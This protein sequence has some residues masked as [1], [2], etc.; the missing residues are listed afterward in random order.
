MRLVGSWRLYRRLSAVRRR[1][2]DYFRLRRAYHCAIGNIRRLG[3]LGGHRASGNGRRA[4]F[5][6][7]KALLDSPAKNGRLA[8]KRQQQ[9][10]FIGRC[11]LVVLHIDELRRQ[12][13]RARVLRIAGLPVFDACFEHR[14]IAAVIKPHA[15]QVQPAL[16][17]VLVGVNHQ[18]VGLIF[19]HRGERFPGRV[20]VLLLL[21]GQAQ[22][23]LLGDQGPQQVQRRLPLAGVNLRLP[24]ARQLVLLKACRIEFAQQR[25]RALEVVLRQLHFYRQQRPFATLRSVKTGR[26]LVEQLNGLR[27]LTFFQQC[28]NGE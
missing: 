26:Q 7:F 2:I 13:F 22:Q 23:R 11:G 19:G 12:H 9:R 17:N 4:V 27:F 21:R 24:V 28:T 25:L 6:R 5:R 14:R 20:D 16:Q 15:L 3:D 10:D 1:Q 8:V 18:R